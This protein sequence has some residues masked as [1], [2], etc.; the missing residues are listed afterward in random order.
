MLAAAG[1]AVGLGNIWRFPY[2]VA[3]F[4][5]GVFLIVYL[6]MA[7]TFGFTLMITE[8]AIGRKTG[9]SVIGAFKKLDKKW[10]FLGVIAAV[11]PVLIIPYYSVIGGWVTKYFATYI[12]GQGEL[13]ASEVFFDNFISHPY[14]PLAW[15][16]VFIIAS[17][18]VVGLGVKKG[19]ERASKVLMP[20]LIVLTIAVAVYSVSM[21]GAIEGV[22]YYFVPDFSKFSPELVLAAMGQMF[23]SMSLAMG[24]MVTYGSYMK[25]SE[26][27]DK[28]VKQIEWFDAGIAIMSGLM[29]IPAVFVFS[30]GMDGVT[31]GPALMFYT[32][33][34][35]FQSMGSAG[36][37]VGAM[38]FM[39]V[40]FAALTS[41]ISMLET[42][43]SVLID[44][45]NMK[46]WAACLITLG[47]IVALAVP[48]SFG[49][50]IWSGITV[51]GMN[52][53]DMFDFASGS[54]LMPIVALLTCIFVGYIKKPSL[55]IDEVEL[56]GAFKRKKMYAA[57]IKY[58]APALVAII[59][60]STL[61]QTAGVVNL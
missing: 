41:A 43:V 9:L 20:V 54:L 2:L 19:I 31:A 60:V 33:P 18:V 44:K 59:L 3:K 7:F 47:I 11:I 12:S 48:N 46:R 8:I 52:I 61:L 55:V 10:T 37:I 50:G 45:F 29:I 4:G 34:K 15:S 21:P 5:G 40:L 51:N 57:F 22:K 6:A 53:L 25:R 42:M 24:T 38:F 28:S 1:S 32:M 58:V 27:L 13:A 56:S 17:V 36:H 35:V 16:W 26:N 39:L 49:F 30:G 14:L 23:L